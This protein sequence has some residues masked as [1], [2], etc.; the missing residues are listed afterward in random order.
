MIRIA[1]C[2]DDSD[3]TE[4]IRQYL[5][6]KNK[7]LHDKTLH[8]SLY[9]SGADFLSAV[10]RETIFHIVFMD[11]QMEGLDGVKVGQLLRKMPNGDVPS[12]IYISH[13]ADHCRELVELEI[14]GFLDKPLREDRLDD[15]LD[16]ALKRANVYGRITAPAPFS[17]QVEAE[18]HTF[19]VDKIVYMKNSKRIIKLYTWNHTDQSICLESKFYSTIDEVLKRLPKGQFIQCERSY[20]VNLAYV[21]WMDKEAFILGDK[22]ETKIPI[23]RRGKEEAAKAYF[24]YKEGSIWL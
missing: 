11:I 8:I 4:H 24:K 5:E 12:I 9:H 17:V 6:A 15:T 3:I 1:V 16:R 14:V 20:I 13:Y 10:E 23:S 7:E 2:D 21:Q 19:Q 18:T 22:E